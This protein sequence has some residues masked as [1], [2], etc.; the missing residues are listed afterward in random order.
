MGPGSQE[1]VLP[2]PQQTD[3]QEPKLR[4]VNTE[5]KGPNESDAES[6]KDSTKNCIV[7]GSTIPS[8]AKYCS[9]CGNS[10]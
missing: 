7:C 4:P 5:V 10:Q 2:T 6:I 8:R 9:R 3:D 1:Y